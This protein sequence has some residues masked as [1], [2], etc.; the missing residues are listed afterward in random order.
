MGILLIKNK[1]KNLKEYAMKVKIG[2]NK[3]RNIKS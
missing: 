2:I 1:Y 3:V